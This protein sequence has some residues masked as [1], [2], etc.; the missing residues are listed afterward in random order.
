MKHV[1][2]LQFGRTLLSIVRAV[3][4]GVMRRGTDCTTP[5]TDEP[6]QGQ[7]WQHHL[8][9]QTLSYVCDREAAECRMEG[10]SRCL[11]GVAN[12]SRISCVAAMHLFIT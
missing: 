10:R 3:C 4:A 2:C 6:E 9:N 5:G 1:S 8:R 11:I 7:H 12:T